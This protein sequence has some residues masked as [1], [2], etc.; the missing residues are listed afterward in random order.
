MLGSGVRVTHA[1][2]FISMTYGYRRQA[3]R[4]RMCNS[5]VIVSSRRAV[6]GP[7]SFRFC[8]CLLH[9]FESLID[10]VSAA[11]GVA[12]HHLNRLM[13]G[14]F[15]NSPDIGASAAR[16][17]LSPAQFGTKQTLPHSWPVFAL[18]DP[19]ERPHTLC[20]N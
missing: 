8:F 19:I 1:A 13:A 18:E 6:P 20:S 4:V 3:I 11:M 12:E 7:N 9:H 5:C 14:E 2:P 15:L 16:F 10:P 17:L